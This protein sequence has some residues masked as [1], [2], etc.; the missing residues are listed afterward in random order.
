[1]SKSTSY[2]PIGNIGNYYGGL[3]IKK[4]EGKYYWLIE[5]YDTNFEDISEWSE[6]EKDLFD[7]LNFHKPKS[8]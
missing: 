2:K 6:I 1:M 4:H 7:K 8:D 3:F 5:N